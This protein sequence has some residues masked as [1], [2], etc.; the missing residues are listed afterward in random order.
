M[1]SSSVQGEV[2]AAVVVIW[3]EELLWVVVGLWG[4]E[5]QDSK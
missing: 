1:G 4:R 5:A 2:A 3:V